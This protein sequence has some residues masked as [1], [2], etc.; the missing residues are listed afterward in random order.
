MFQGRCDGDCREFATFTEA[1]KFAENSIHE[2]GKVSWH[3]DGGRL[4]LRADGTWE[5]LT[6]KSLAIIAAAMHDE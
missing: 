3:F 1:R 5:H 4:I 2:L 6:A